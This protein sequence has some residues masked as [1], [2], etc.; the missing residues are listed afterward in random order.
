M[1]NNKEKSIIEAILFSI[2][3]AVDIAKLAE[4]LECSIEHVK[5]IAKDLES[6]YESNERG[7]K[8]VEIDG[9]Y[10]L[11][12]KSELY[13]YLIKIVKIPKDYK[14]TDV[15]LETLSIIAYKQPVTK[16]EIEKIRGVASD[17]A[18]NRLVDVGLVEEKGRLAT[19]GRPLVFGTTEEFLRR[20]GLKNKEDLPDINTDKVEEMRLEAEEEIG[21]I[22]EKKE[23]E[24][25]IKPNED[26]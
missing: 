5:E 6:D 23:E 8:L 14:L 21:Y 13:P 2:G 12:T 25:V 7:L 20:F 17:H 24:A 11:C 19:P 18:V 15:Q 3:D 22:D 9:A 1:E 26:E 10:Q 4:V 16:I